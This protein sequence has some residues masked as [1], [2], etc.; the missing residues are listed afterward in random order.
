MK[1]SQDKMKELGEFL[2]TRRARLT[3]EQ[4]G[5]PSTGTRRTP[6]LRRAE[7]A[8]LAG[9]S[10]DWYTWLEQGRDI[11]VSDQ[12]LESLARTLQLSGSE[13][14]HL[15]LL[16]AG[17]L[18]REE[19]EPQS[20]VGPL[21][22]RFLDEQGASPAFVVNSR[23]DVVGWNRAA[24]LVFGDYEA[25]GARERNS[26]WR[27][28]TTP[29]ARQ[30]LGERWEENSKHRLAQFR[31]N[32]ARAAEEPWWT[33]MIEDLSRTSEEF[34]EWW[35]LHEVV[36]APEGEKRLYH[37]A[38][39]RLRFGHLSFQAMDSV[40]LQVTVNLPLDEDTRERMNKLLGS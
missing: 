28:F 9:I 3:P 25:M 24:A 10:I 22:Q 18:P 4:L 38:A 1:G 33:E 26:V 12:V 8:V 32:Y 21:L 29:Y 15:F 5:L 11:R 16:A 7:V 13:R 2:R 20:G 34:R 23:W 27:L 30:L 19:R 36:H 17:H 6:G 35:P 14:R 40:D 31:A 37:P 39:G